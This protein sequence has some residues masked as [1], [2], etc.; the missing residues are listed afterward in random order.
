RGLIGFLGIEWDDACLRF[1]ET[2]RTVRTPSRWQV[3]QPIYSSSVE[4]WK[5][6]GDALDPLKAALG[7][8]L[9]R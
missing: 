6:Y 2:E 9:Q 4:R 7:P 3:R 8:V 5:L 1:H